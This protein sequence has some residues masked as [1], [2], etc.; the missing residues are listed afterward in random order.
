[1]L[2]VLTMK[3]IFQFKAIAESHH[4]LKNNIQKANLQYKIS[5]G[6]GGK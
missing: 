5:I 4:I 3:Q 6:L 2:K 1:M